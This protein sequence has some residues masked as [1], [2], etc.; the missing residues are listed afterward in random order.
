MTLLLLPIGLGATTPSY[1][2]AAFQ[3]LWYYFGKCQSEWKM[4]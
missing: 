4:T 1:V 2:S 3:V